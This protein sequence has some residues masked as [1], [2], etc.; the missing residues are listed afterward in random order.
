MFNSKTEAKEKVES[1]LQADVK[2]VVP[3]Y[4]DV[5]GI[6]QFGYEIGHP[7][8]PAYDDSWK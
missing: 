6:V 5:K 2:S 8:Y 3:P 7:A 1:N 4:F